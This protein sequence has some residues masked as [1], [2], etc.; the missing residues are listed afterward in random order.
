[1]KT[2][3]K[4]FIGAW[5]RTLPKVGPYVASKSWHKIVHYGLKASLDTT[6]LTLEAR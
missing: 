4:P 5:R 1:M 3:D 2:N 6:R